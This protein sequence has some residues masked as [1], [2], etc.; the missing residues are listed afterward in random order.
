[1]DKKQPTQISS[2]SELIEW[3]KQLELDYNNHPF[4]GNYLFQ[5]VPNDIYEINASAYRRL[6]SENKDFNKFRR[7]TEEL[8]KDTR[9][10]G[11]GER[12]GRELYDLEILAQLQHFGAATCLID[13]TY[14]ALTALWFAC[15]QDSGKVT[16]GKVVMVQTLQL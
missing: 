6:G 11:H 4:R 16:D 8:I 3:V 2:L 9:Q 7:L 10:R 13:F 12:N 15:Q 1:M 5:G 14:N